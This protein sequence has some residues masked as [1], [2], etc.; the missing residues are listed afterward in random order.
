MKEKHVLVTGAGGYMG[1][2]VVSILLD[3]GM[4]VTAV[5]IHV[6]GIDQRAKRLQYN[7]FSGE[8]DIYQKLGEPDVCL[9]LAWKEGFVHN[10]NA[11][12]EYLSAHYL[13]AEN[14][15]E[16]GLK[17]F[18]ALGSM[19][20]VGYYEGA[21]DENT[22][23]SPMSL[24]GVAK[25]AL[26]QSLDLLSKQK[27]I[28]FQWLRGYYITGDDLKSHSIFTK[29]LEAE[30]EG[31]EKFPL[32]KGI[33]KYDFISIENLAREI[34]LVVT[35]SEVQGTINCSSGKPVSLK[36]KVEEFI[37]SKDLKIRPE[38][39]VFPERSYDS[40]IVYGDTKKIA[41]IIQQAE[42]NE[43]VKKAIKE[44]KSVV[45]L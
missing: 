17:Q 29:I 23:C 38:Y 37:K 41:R 1:R 11:H 33:N 7:I 5:D 39:G 13:F 36:D 16:G 4:Q 26:R 19:H 8:N 25:N 34:A 3:F 14:M 30:E 22:P 35:Q 45:L 32:N 6:D 2:H 9:H 40:P 43:E 28:C 21:I 42:G 15:I 27:D 18:A 24:Y 44:L 20:E 31:K 10:S 12:M